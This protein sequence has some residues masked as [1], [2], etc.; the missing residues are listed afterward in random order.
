MSLLYLPEALYIT[1]SARA[2]SSELY[3]PGTLSQ[4]QAHHLEEQ[5]HGAEGRRGRRTSGRRPRSQQGFGKAKQARQPTQ[6]A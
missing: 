1:V 5:H 4:A 6:T 2:E 3:P